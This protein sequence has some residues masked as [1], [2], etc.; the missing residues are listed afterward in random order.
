M[1]NAAE[2]IESS[3]EAEV[4]RSDR[5]VLVDFGA[6]WCPP[7][8]MLDPVVD[9]LAREYEGRLKVAKVDVDANP[10]LARDYDIMSVPTLIVFHKGT[11]VSRFVGFMPK[12]DLKKKL[13]NALDAAQDPVPHPKA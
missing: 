1:G 13:E 7:C 5:P 10:H 11:P 2:V 6:D 8:R 4:L 12:G 3:F 9:D